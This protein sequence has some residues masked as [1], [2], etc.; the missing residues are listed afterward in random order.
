MTSRL[1][2]L[3]VPFA[4]YIPIS[5]GNKFAYFPLCCAI[6][7]YIAQVTYWQPVDSC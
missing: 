3:T 6:F 1:S 4:F 5:V 7:I 2:V